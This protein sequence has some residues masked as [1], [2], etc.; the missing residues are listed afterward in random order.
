MSVDGEVINV[1]IME[2]FHEF[3][4][5]DQLKTDVYCLFIM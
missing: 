5:K 4:E 3:K 2:V 1:S